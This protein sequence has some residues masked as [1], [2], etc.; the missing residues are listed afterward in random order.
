MRLELELLVLYVNGY[1]VKTEFFGYFVKM[2]QF[3]RHSAETGNVILFR[4][5][6]TKTTYLYSH[7]ILE[8]LSSS[9]VQEK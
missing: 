6:S 8:I 2:P 1:L 4:D 7:N 5:H 3:A 9:L